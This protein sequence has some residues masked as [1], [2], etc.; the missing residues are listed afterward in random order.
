MPARGGVT[1]Q[2][3]TPPFDV[4]IIG[5]SLA[6]SA[7]AIRLG[8]AGVSVALVDKSNFPRTKACGEGFSRHG[9]QQ[10]RALGLDISPLIDES[11]AFYGYKF[12]AVQAPHRACVVSAPSPR[13]WGIPRTS[14]DSA[15]LA[16]ATNHTSVKPFL[17]HTVRTVRHDGQVW[18]I[19]CDSNSLSARHLFVAAGAAT[20]S[21]VRQYIT[22]LSQPSNR[23]G[24]TLHGELKSGDLTN[25]VTILPL[26]GGEVYLTRLDSG[27]LNISLVGS[28]DFIQTHRA[29]DRLT[30]ML[31]SSLGIQVS[32]SL[33]AHGGSH[34]QVRRKSNHPNLFLL[35][36]AAESFDPA[37]GFGMTHALYTGIIASDSLIDALKNG[38][39][40]AYSSRAYVS[41]Q[42]RCARGIRSF[43]H[44][45]RL[46]MQC[47]RFAPRP[48]IAMSGLRASRL[49]EFLERHTLSVVVPPLNSSFDRVQ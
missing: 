24:Y 37:C 40:S 7:A 18:S 49:M 22:N 8:Q 12:V 19:S 23:I 28:T 29:A 32:I 35:G 46:F 25:L 44:I 4:A 6:G 47:F 26:R 14:L 20:D 11:T 27:R 41:K 15:L 9:V 43:S 2:T 48:L 1:M 33:P 5:A 10:L 34:F 38:R 16:T 36:D 31:E 13:G 21:F 17:H 30:A 45:V 3:D 42:V 39:S